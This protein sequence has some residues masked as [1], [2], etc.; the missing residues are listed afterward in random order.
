MKRLNKIRTTTLLCAGVVLV[1]IIAC[2]TQKKSSAGTVPTVSAGEVKSTSNRYKPTNTNAPEGL[3]LGN[4]APELA[5]MNPNDS[6]IKLSSLR[7][8]IVLIDFWAS[9]C[10]PCRHENPTV[11][12]AYTKYKN[13]KLK[14]ANGFTIYSLSL[15]MDKNAWKNAI[16]KD[17][18]IWPYHVSDLKGW[19][20]VGAQQ[21]GIQGI[22]NN[23][24]LDAD[25]LIIARNLRGPALEK[26]LEQLLDIP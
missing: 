2:G 15:D 7:G 21:Y 1:S 17:G 26:A 9:W 8:Q 18:L 23:Y 13:A 6:I 4:K 20:S 11:V 3:N 10:G 25:G 24:L 5:F 14:N 22:P 19:G 12:A 16:V